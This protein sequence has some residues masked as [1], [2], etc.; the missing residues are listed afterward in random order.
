MSSPV[1]PCRLLH[2]HTAT[3]PKRAPV[4]PCLPSSTPV[5]PCLPLSTPVYCHL[6]L[7]AP[8]RLVRPAAKG[9]ASHCSTQTSAGCAPMFRRGF[10]DGGERKDN[11]RL[12]PQDSPWHVSMYH[13]ACI[14]RMRPCSL[15]YSHSKLFRYVV[16]FRL[17]SCR[18]RS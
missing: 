7:H 2:P 11:D 18:S 14:C 15:D 6:P 9:R 12:T 4:Y 10:G 5:Y 17:R 1:Y 8:L 3:C 16:V 13:A